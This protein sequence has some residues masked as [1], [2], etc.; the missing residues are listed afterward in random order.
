M[1]I[2]E[3]SRSIKQ[4]LTLSTKE[5]SLNIITKHHA[6]NRY[7]DFEEILRIVIEIFH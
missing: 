6:Q 4:N 7:R 1:T 5:Q 2:E 3:G